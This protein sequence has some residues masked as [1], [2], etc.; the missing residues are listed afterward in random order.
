MGAISEDL[1]VFSYYRNVWAVAS[2]R[3]DEAQRRSQYGVRFLSRAQVQAW[4]P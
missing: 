3:Y 2:G 4:K 1:K